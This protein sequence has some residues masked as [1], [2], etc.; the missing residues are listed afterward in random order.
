MADQGRKTLT[1]GN[2]TISGGHD[3][4]FGGPGN[5]VIY[6]GLGNDALTQVGG[7]D[8]LVAGD[9]IDTM[10]F[11]GT[12]SATANL[13]VTAAQATGYGVDIS[14]GIEN[15]TGTAA[16]DALIGNT[17]SNLLNGGGGADRIGLW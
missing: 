16:A 3:H 4:H 12:L 11:S 17:T 13:A 9:G 2:D 14:S 15:L 8:T 5:N 6:G 1:A 7:N 10:V